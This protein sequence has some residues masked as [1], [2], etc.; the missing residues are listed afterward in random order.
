LLQSF[1]GIT[2]QLAAI[3]RLLAQ[4]G[5]EGAEA[6]KGVLA[7]ADTALRDA[8]HMI[9]DMRPV[10]LEDRDLAAALET[11]AHSAMAESPARLVFAVKGDRR[12]LP[13]SVETTALRVGSEAVLNAVKHAAPRTVEVSIEYE[14]R[15]V[16]VRVLDDG[17]GIAPGAM[18][19]AVRGKHLGITGMRD[20]A[21]RAGGTL[22]IA[23]EPGRGTAVSV[24][25]P[26][27]EPPATSPGYKG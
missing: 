12:R 1:T 26:I 16:T 7:S 8:R 20:R 19:A 4:R 6:L 2:L 3:Q 23:S 13:V 27:G 24:S 22:E 15:F 5:Q 25:L 18:D 21:Q 14:P 11:A 17:A 10:E 9:W